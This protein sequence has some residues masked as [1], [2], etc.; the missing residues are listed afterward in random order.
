MIV[1]RL[2]LILFS[3]TFVRI[4]QLYIYGCFLYMS[5]FPL[6]S[7]QTGKA[8]IC[9]NLRQRYLVLAKHWKTTS[10]LDKLFVNCAITNDGKQSKGCIIKTTKGNITTYRQIL[11]GAD[12]ANCN[13]LKSFL[14]LKDIGK[15]SNRRMFSSDIAMMSVMVHT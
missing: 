4:H 2:L 15:Q 8:L 9:T 3:E 6:I 5:A 12:N 14:R 10:D 11:K 1:G 7:T 13:N